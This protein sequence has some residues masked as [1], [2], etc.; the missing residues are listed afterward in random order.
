[1]CR[2][3]AQYPAFA[4]NTLFLLLAL[5]KWQ[6]SFFVFCIFLSIICPKYTCTQLFLVPYS[7]F[8]FCCSRRC[9]SRCKHCSTVAKSPRFQPVSPPGDQSRGLN[10]CLRQL[11]A[12]TLLLGIS[13]VEGYDYA[14]W[15]STYLYP[16]CKNR[17][18]RRKT[19]LSHH[20]T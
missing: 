10:E 11:L 18:V 15:V 19:I 2:G 12:L 5:R 8:V 7:F 4:P 16:G 1:M 13:S 3:R 9:L 17:N 14:C 6:L 20:C